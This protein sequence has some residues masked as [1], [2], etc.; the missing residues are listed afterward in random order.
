MPE[1]M[2]NSHI[3]LTVSDCDRAAA[4]WQD[5]VVGFT[6][7]NRTSTNT[8]ETRSLVHPSGVVVTVMSHN[9]TAEM[10]AFDERRVGLD[11]LALRVADVDELQRWVTHLEAKGVRHS[12]IVDI[13]YGATVVFRDP[14][15]IQLEFYVQPSADELQLNAAD[16]EEARRVLA[17]AVERIAPGGLTP[18][19]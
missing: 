19:G 11:H 5:V 7:V 15:D 2:G 6:L 9:G 8:F 14:D 13:R 16:S 1:L 17:D 10:G 18:I 4:W 3:D 12:G